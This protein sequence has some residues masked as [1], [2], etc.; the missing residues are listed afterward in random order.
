MKGILDL[1]DAFYSAPVGDAEAIIIIKGQ[2]LIGSVGLTDGV[3]LTVKA[4]GDW[5]LDISRRFHW[6]PSISEQAGKTS[7]GRHPRTFLRSCSF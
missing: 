4:G 1:L 5:P 7:R 6:V 2:V 3:W